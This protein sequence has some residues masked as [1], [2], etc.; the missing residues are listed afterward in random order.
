MLNADRLRLLKLGAIFV[1]TARGK[2]ADE[3]ALYELAQ[4]STS[5]G[6]RATYS[7]SSRHRLTICFDSYPTWTRS[8]HLTWS[9]TQPK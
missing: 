4:R 1:N 3:A 2:I 8:S 6:L 5:A 9:G 7:T